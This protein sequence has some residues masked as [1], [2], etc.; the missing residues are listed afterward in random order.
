M[1]YLICIKL[2]FDTN[3]TGYLLFFSLL[4]VYFVFNLVGDS[5]SC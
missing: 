5:F 1:D 4:S 2:V 3:K